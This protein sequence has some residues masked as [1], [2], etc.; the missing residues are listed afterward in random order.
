MDVKEDIFGMRTCMVSGRIRTCFLLFLL[1]L[2]FLILNSCS[3][4]NSV[5]EAPIESPEDFSLKGTEVIPDK[6]WF[7]FDDSELN[8]LVATVLDNNLIMEQNWQE[9]VA[10]LALVKREKSFLFPEVN[11]TAG[12]FLERPESEFGPGENIHAGLSA[13]Y[14]VDLWGRIR[15]AVDAEEFRAEAVFWDYR[16]AGMSISAETAIT[17]YELLTARSQLTLVNKQIETNEDIVRLIRARFAGGQIRAVDILRQEQLLESTR[18]QKIAYETAIELL[19]NQLAVLLGQPPQNDLELPQDSLPALPPLPE[20]GLPLELIRRRPDVQQA[21]HLVLAADREMAVAIRNKYP[22]LS[23]DVTGDV[24]SDNAS[25]LFQNWAYSLAGNLVAPLLYG[26]RLNAEVERAE[27]IKVQRLY[28]YGQ[29][30][31]VAFQEVEDALIREQQQ[32]R[33]LEILERQLDL[34]EKTSRQLRISFLNGLS[35][36]LDVLLSLDEE[37]QL[38]RDLREERQTLLEIRIS[39]YRALAGG[40]ETERENLLIE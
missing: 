7:A 5:V 1:S 27:A 39:L 18:A 11:A 36:Y 28:Q 23:I 3:P 15:A 26:G 9:F 10:A 40:F 8:D 12:A 14:E 13:S 33:R 30:V 16:S 21:Y 31:L 17:W 37:Q 34:A 25:S 35:D 4:Q 2:V 24:I 29:T 20:T 19:E 22:R 38:Q 6:W 32:K